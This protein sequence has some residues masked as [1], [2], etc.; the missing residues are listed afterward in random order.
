M[1]LT[2]NGIRQKVMHF[3]GEHLF[4]WPYVALGGRV[5]SSSVSFPQ[6]DSGA[7]LFCRK[8]GPYFL[9]G[10]VTWGSV[11]CDAEKPAIFSRI[12]A[13]HSW[14]TEVTDDIWLFF[15]YYLIE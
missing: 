1:L 9:F 8:R 5:K 11:R 13:Y 7:P 15:S 3:H 10:L 14:I 12:S 2:Y 6:G 4:L